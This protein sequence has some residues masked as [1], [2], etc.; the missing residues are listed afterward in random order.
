MTKQSHI[1]RRD[2][3]KLSAYIDGAL[4][5][6]KTARLKARLRTDPLLQHALEELR[7]TVRLLGML[8]E[9]T[10]PRNFTLTP[11]MVGMK[12]RPRALPVMQLATA[13]ATLAFL[14]VVGIDAITSP[15]F[16]RAAAP[17]AKEQ[18]ALE[19]PASAANAFREADAPLEGWVAEETDAIRLES[20]VVADEELG[21]EAYAFD[22]A[23]PTI[24]PGV[25]EHVTG[26]TADGGLDETRALAPTD[27]LDS[28][29]GEAPPTME[30][31]AVGGAS[32]EETSMPSPT[33]TALSVV[34][35]SPSPGI[36]E[37]VGAQPW[38]TL[39]LAEVGLGV[40]A[41]VLAVLTI[42]IRRKN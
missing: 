32:A 14:V 23:Q 10:V 24:A 28:V 8:P 33:E 19:A 11:E 2:L 6:K 35:V 37:T 42:W 20:E 21:E 25:P 12:E 9:E 36:V 17:A 41:A 31:L 30:K 1:S 40:V 29:A 18:I 34:A 27:T 16:L 13:M 4:S 26:A 15:M 3:A 22:L 38:S 7:E 5:A 39:R